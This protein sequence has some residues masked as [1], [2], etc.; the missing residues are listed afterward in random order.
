MLQSIPGQ[1]HPP[2]EITLETPQRA[3]LSRQIDA[4]VAALQSILIEY[5][6]LQSLAQNI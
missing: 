1:S 6:H 5:R 2:F 3:P 4:L